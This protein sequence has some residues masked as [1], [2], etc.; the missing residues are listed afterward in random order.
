MANVYLN[1]EKYQKTKKKLISVAFIFLILGIIVGGILIFTGNQK[2]KQHEISIQE[3]LDTIKTK[4][5]ELEKQLADKSYECNS[6]D[7]NNPNW[8]AESGK[9]TDEETKIRVEL[10]KLDSEEVSLE[11]QAGPAII[12]YV[13]GGMSIF[14]G[15]VIFGSI[16]MTAKRREIA[17]F[18]AQQMMP[19][20]QEGIDTMAPT[21]GNATKE[22]AKGIKEGLKDNK[23]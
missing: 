3:K 4:R 13:L 15:L 18:G 5:T 10:G 23:E 11:H 20:A 7:M 9:C 8:F 21:V 17:A 14:I 22:I 6:L 12:F 16:Y 2:E 19:I 1:E